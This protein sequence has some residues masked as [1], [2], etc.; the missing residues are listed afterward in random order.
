MTNKERDIDGIL[1]GSLQALKAQEWDRSSALS[2]YAI[3]TMMNE[4]GQTQAPATPAPV[5]VETPEPKRA[6]PVRTSAA[7]DADCKR[8]GERFNSKGGRFEYCFKCGKTVQ[9]ICQ[10]CGKNRH[11]PQFS[12]CRECGY[13]QAA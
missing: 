4:S 8:C 5:E 12:E 10:K 2:L 7:G 6:A 11:M 9:V 13:G 3:A 1:S